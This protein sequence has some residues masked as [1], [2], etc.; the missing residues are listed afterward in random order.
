MNIGCF[1]NVVQL[2]CGGMGTVY[3]GF[4]K[5]KKVAIKKFR[6]DFMSKDE[7]KKR[8]QLEGKTL[9]RLNHPSI[10]KIIEPA[11]N[12]NNLF[13]PAFEEN[14]ALYLAME[15]IEGET[16]DRYVQERGPLNEDKVVRIMCN[17]LDAMEYVRQQGIVHRDIKPSN[18]ILR[19]DEESVCIIDFG[20]VKDL[21]SVGMTTGH[22]AFGTDGYMSPEQADGLTVD[23]RTDIYSLGCLLF[24]ML[25]G[26]HAITK[27]ASDHETKIAIIHDDFPRAKDINPNISY[28]IQGIIDKAVDKNM[29][30]RFQSPN[31]FR[32]ALNN[33]NPTQ[34]D[35]AIRLN[36][37]PV[38]SV[39]RDNS[40]D[41]TIYDS[42]EKVSRHH[43]DIVYHPSTDEFEFVDRSTNGT[44]V[45]GVFIHKSSCKIYFPYDWYNLKADVIPTIILAQAQTLDWVAV[46]DKF[47]KK[48]CP[49]HDST[50]VGV[51]PHSDKR[52]IG[53]GVISF[54]FPLVGWILYYK[55]KQTKP[56]K[57]KQV[58]NLAW[59]GFVLNLILSVII[60]I[61]QI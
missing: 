47:G 50:G 37:D 56:K 46:L 39:G 9:Q 43:L 8:F 30:H 54:L 5:G 38:I 20:I 41:I 1:N 42:L 18:I 10:V 23:S 3:S 40:C 14:G 16:I 49:M 52:S 15:F 51:N 26:T 34:L 27:K 59:A 32:M 2:G 11:H 4:Y 45:N 28:H 31:E 22:C 17:I 53:Y 19:P 25:T 21:N 48:K 13:Y 55:W 6:T 29:L 61:S 7:L 12:T 60:D 24:Y 44:H 58:S 33:S 36:S 35:S 57:A